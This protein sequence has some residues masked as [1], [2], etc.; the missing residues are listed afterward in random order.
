M[1]DGRGWPPPAELERY[2]A[3]AWIITRALA[4]EFRVCQ[5]PLGARDPEGAESGPGPGGGADLSAVLTRFLGALFLEMERHVTV[6]QKVRRAVP[7]SPCGEGSGG[8][9]EPRPVSVDVPR[10]LESFRLGQRNLQDVWRLV[11]PPAT[12]L[13][14]GKLAQRP[15]PGFRFSDTLW[16]RIVYDFALAHRLR[17]MNRDHLLAAFVPLYLGWLGSFVL[18]LT[19][20]GSAAETAELAANAVKFAEEAPLAEPEEDL[21]ALAA[22]DEAE[23]VSEREFVLLYGE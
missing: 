14:L 19:T 10:A 2:G 6:W 17:V 7:V 3:E 15:D 9:G 13:E 5:A 23:W 11:L 8:D 22:Q 21:E 18:E 12:L 16:A 4:G 1:V 20:E